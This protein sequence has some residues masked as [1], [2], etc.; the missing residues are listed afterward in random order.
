V[1]AVGERVVQLG[2]VV[3]EDALED[4]LVVVAAALVVGRARG[5]GEDVVLGELGGGGEDCVGDGAG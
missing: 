3:R 4:L 1:V 2:E 5:L